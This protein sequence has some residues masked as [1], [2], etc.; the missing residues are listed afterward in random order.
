MPPFQKKLYLEHVAGELDP[1]A[2]RTLFKNSVCCVEIEVHSYCNR[3]C[4]FCP[5]SFID[6]HSRRAYLPAETYEAILA[7]LAEIDYDQ[8]L[9]FSRYNEPLADRVI[10]DRLKAAH[11]TIPKARLHLN[12]NGDYL[13]PAY[14]EELYEAGLRSMKIQIYL[15]N[16]ETYTDERVQVRAKQILDKLGLPAALLVDKPDEW[17]EYG[18]AYRDMEITLYARNFRRNGTD[19]GGLLDIRPV[20]ARKMPC[21]M[22]VWAIYVDYTGHMVPCCN[23]RSDAPS[24]QPYILGRLSP[25]TDIFSIYT[26]PKAAAFRRLVLNFKE[27]QGVCSHCSFAIEKLNR[28]QS[29]VMEK[30]NVTTKPKT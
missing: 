4:W 29:L 18:L 12:T 23:I 8:I 21:L 27:K 13:T 5:N 24:H 19:R 17:L 11:Q 7:N 10:L 14:L 16:D 22:P 15:Q 26:G 20:D 25:E 28:E 3:Q 6:R 30:I 1:Q 2:A 9:S